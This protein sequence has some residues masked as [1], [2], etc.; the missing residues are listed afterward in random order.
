MDKVKNI[1]ILYN[2]KLNKKN[3]Y[4]NIINTFIYK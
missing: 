3:Y 1:K 4:K 2:Y